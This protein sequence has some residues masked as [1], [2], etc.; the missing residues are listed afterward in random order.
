MCNVILVAFLIL[1]VSEVYKSK[2]KSIC[3]YTY[4]YLFIPSLPH[5]YSQQVLQELLHNLST[6]Y[7]RLTILIIG[8]LPL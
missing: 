5:L 8:I 2:Q 4:N 3:V 7:L 6:A 1:N